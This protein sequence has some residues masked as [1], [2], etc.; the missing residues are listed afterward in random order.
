L[1]EGLEISEVMLSY[2]QRKNDA[3]RFDSN[4]FQKEY[5]VE[6]QLIQ[7]K[8][9]ATLSSL[10]VGL[11]SFGAYS[12]N[13]EVTYLDEGVP[14]VRGV[15]MKH[16][17]ISFTNMTYISEKANSLLWKSAVKPEMILL[18][19]SGTIGEVAIASK[20][21]TYPINSNQDIAK[22][23]TKGKINPYYL[24]VF[25]LT[26]FGQNF[27]AREARGSVQQHVFLSQIENLDVPEFG[28]KFSI[29]IE[30]AIHKSD[31]A[32]RCSEIKIQDAEKLL[33]ST[34]GIANFLP[35]AET[36][37][38]KSFKQSFA[39]TGRLDPEHY[40]PKFDQLE[41]ALGSFP[42]GTTTVGALADEI[43]NGAEVR[44]YQAEGTP[45][46]RIGDLKFLDVDASSVVRID[47]ASAKSGLEKIGLKA[48]DVLL[49]RS[50]SLAVSAV[51]EPAWESALISSHLIRLR[52]R[53]SR[54]D[55]YFLALFFMTLPGKMQI[56]KWSNGGVQPEISQPAVK[57][58]TVP[59]LPWP[60]QQEIR[61]LIL[62][63]RALRTKSDNLLQAAKRAVE[64]AIEQNEAAGMAYLQAAMPS[65][66][67]V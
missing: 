1:L 27:L 3:F 14:F 25:L 37:N 48:G 61:R 45:Y 54:I 28:S 56:Q 26:K 35:L 38:I 67:A 60:E 62:L 42:G 64:I 66:V 18:S 31:D 17:R 7:K 40:Q 51:V 32:Q 41:N 52:I 50:G 13:S 4:F 21:W 34:M 46:L 10:G 65:G 59:V 55:P 8:N 36:V 57:V 20:D 43:A 44:E 39:A 47:P 63:A 23:D 11:K 49:S 29:Q 33:L 12:L 9:P 2:V 24:Y 22:I 58:I 19:M 5:L 30:K 53:D 15:N 16:G 6:E